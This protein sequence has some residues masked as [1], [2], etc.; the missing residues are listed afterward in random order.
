MDKPLCTG[1]ENQGV[2][3][4]CGGELR[5]RRKVYCS[6]ECHDLYLD[7]F[8]WPFARDAA[9][10]RATRKCQI[11]GVTRK[12]LAKICRNHSWGHWGLSVHHLEPVK[13]ATRTWHVLNIPSNL[14][15]VCHDCHVLLHT[16][17]YWKSQ[18]RRQMQ[19][20]LL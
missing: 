6:A 4:M 12:G 9:I 1:Y 16:P 20:A 19:P 18:E 13:G 10:R 5:G 8:F 3:V 7:L 2:C 14:L 17:S 15:V 11:C